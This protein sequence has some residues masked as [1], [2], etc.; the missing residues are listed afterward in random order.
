MTHPHLVSPPRPPPRSRRG[1]A[2]AAIAVCPQPPGTFARVW[3]ADRPGALAIS[4]LT[5]VAAVIPP[6]VAYVGKLIVD[7]VVRSTRSGEA[8]DR[9]AVVWLVVLELGLMI[10]STT[11]A[12]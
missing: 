5:A 9:R 3:R 8:A 10:A 7:G 6:A 12:R 11:V 4:L 2:S 1:R